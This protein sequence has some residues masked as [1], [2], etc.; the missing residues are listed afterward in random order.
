MST[1][2]IAGIYNYCD[3]WCERCAFTARCLV[4]AREKKYFGDKAEHDL[5]SDAFWKTMTEIFSDTKTLI[6]RA[7]E[8]HGID[9]NSVDQE[10]LDRE[11]KAMAKIQRRARR[12]RL[13]VQATG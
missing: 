11:M 6:Q 9:L 10:E 3:R 1:D 8:E 4:F 13:V 5:K 7:A 12:D 2:F